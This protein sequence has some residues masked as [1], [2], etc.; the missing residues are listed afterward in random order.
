MDSLLNCDRPPAFCPGCS[1]TPVTRALDRCL[2]RLGLTADRVVIVSD[3]GCSGLF[4]TFFHTHAF[5]GLH[6]RA[7]T[8]ATGIKMAQPKLTVI[9]TMGDG[10]LGIGAA[11]FLAACRRNLDLTL[12]ILNNFNFAMTGGQASVTTPDTAR[13]S[14]GFLNRLEKPMDIHQVAAAAGA[15]YSVRCASHDK[16][17][18]DIIGDAIAFNGFSV[19]DIWGVCPGRYV[20]KNRLNPKIIDDSLKALPPTPGPVAENLRAEYGR[21]YR[22]LSRNFSEPSGPL[23]IS[24]DFMPLRMKRQEILF[25]GGA[26]QRIITAGELLCLAAMNGGWSVTQ[27]NQ[28][29]ITVLRGPSI[30]EVILSPEPVDFTGIR[31]PDWIL[32]LQQEGVDRKRKVFSRASEE[33]TLI[34]VQ[35]IQ[36]PESFPGRVITVDLKSLGISAADTA[37]GALGYLCR[38]SRLISEAMMKNALAVRY[39]GSVL[40]NALR[41]IETVFST[42]P[43]GETR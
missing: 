17:L 26:G 20:Q 1:H 27:K 24:A 43:P 6:G 13:V 18:A 14:S 9:V 39:K 15:P 12:L 23:Q 4:D 22:E 42:D 41:I 38:S 25:L 34:R 28:Y 10:G 19:V 7:L 2:V 21:Q 29:D 37:L 32:A 36:L 35:G 40:E 31:R 30:S 16:H 5:H 33:T 3:I 8:Y 11:H